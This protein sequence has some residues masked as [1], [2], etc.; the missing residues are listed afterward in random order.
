MLFATIPIRNFLPG[1]PPPGSWVDVTIVLW[2]V[3]ALGVALVFGV[4][5]WWRYGR[6]DGQR[7]AVPPADPR[8]SPTVAAALPTNGVSR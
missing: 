6:T 7:P 5:S 8:S 2:V 1:S 4:G 3:V